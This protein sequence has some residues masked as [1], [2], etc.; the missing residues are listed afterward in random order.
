MRDCSPL[1]GVIPMT[2]LDAPFP[3]QDCVRVVMLLVQSS[4]PMRFLT[5]PRGQVLPG[6]CVLLPHSRDGSVQ[7]AERWAQAAVPG[8]KL[9]GFLAADERHSRSHSTHVVVVS[10]EELTPGQARGALPRGDAVV[11]PEAL[12][13]HSETPR[14]T[15]ATLTAL[16]D[17][18]AYEIALQAPPEQVC[19]R[20]WLMPGETSALPKACRLQAL[21]VQ[22][23]CWRGQQQG[24]S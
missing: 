11:D 9:H 2:Y 16:V 10:I 1:P 12:A 15:W 24:Q 5:G 8:R 22:V 3:S 19:F 7:R 23:Q 4:S 17:A 18:P 21:C 13:S 20:R 14:C 6:E